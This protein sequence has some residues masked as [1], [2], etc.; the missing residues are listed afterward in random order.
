MAL[1]FCSNCGNKISDKAPACPKCGAVNTMYTAQ[2]LQTNVTVNVENTP[3]KAE[4]ERKKKILKT[5]IAIVSVVLVLAGA[6][7]AGMIII[8]KNPNVKKLEIESWDFHDEQDY[9][10]GDGYFIGTI[11]SDNKNPFIAVITKKSTDT[12]AES[13]SEAE[14]KTDTEANTKT[15]T[16]TDTD[17]SKERPKYET[18]SYLPQ[19]YAYMQ[20]G[21]GTF[22]LSGDEEPNDY[23]IDSYLVGTPLDEKDFTSIKYDYTDYNDDFYPN[24]T[25]AYFDVQLS[26]KKPQNGMLFCSFHN[27]ATNE[28]LE[29]T[30]AAVVN[31]EVLVS[32]N[33]CVLPYKSRDPKAIVIQDMY[34]VPLTPIQES[35]YVAD[36]Y[37]FKRTDDG[38]HSCS[39][40]WEMTL[41]TPINGFL[42][43]S[44]TLTEGGKKEDI[45]K[46]QFK[47]TPISNGKSH[48]IIF[49]W[50]DDE[51]FENPQYTHRYYGY[52]EAKKSGNN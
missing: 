20:G 49:D 46:E 22:K 43:Y 12:E 19:Y 48:I 50:Y 51:N 1:V 3:I 37:Y 41:N 39:W 18:I 23:T 17:S 30:C 14:T 34:F 9:Y 26:M 29:M 24:Q 40:E 36:K 2:N 7:T 13:E 32:T 25:I 47:V 28:N 27:N 33:R 38:L 44:T 21:K 4:P 16:D 52:I 35:D 42:I 6:I 45:N 11:T 8:G 15:N 10:Y 31:G 5:A